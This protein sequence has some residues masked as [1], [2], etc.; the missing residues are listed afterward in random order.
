[1]QFEYPSQRFQDWLSQ[2]WVMW[3]GR[4]IN[5][6]EYPWLMGPFGN[7]DVIGDHYIE[8]LA[9]KENL[10]VERPEQNAGLLSSFEEV[11]AAGALN[12]PI[13]PE[14]VSFYTD[15][16]SH[17]MEVWSQWSTMFRPFGWL[18]HRLYSRRLQ[19]LNMPLQPLDTSRGM[20]SEII[21]LVDPATS[22]IKYTIWLRILKSTGQVIYSG[23]YGTSTTPSGDACVKVIFPLPRGN[24]TVLL[25]AQTDESG[26]LSL[27]SS[28]ERFGCPGFYFLLVDSKG[29]HWA[30]Y[31]RSFR[32]RIDVYGD[33]E[34]TLRADHTLT[35]WKRRV[36]ALHYRIDRKSEK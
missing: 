6:D 4:Q 26:N 18:L 8:Q 22:A 28:G 19:Q 25:R 1:M 3:R 11:E 34:G 29:R 13:R 36:L 27:I 17:H 20:R 31:V 30:Q 32:E 9:A 15:T 16:T 7:V 24:A 23:V 21:R 14:V 5:P 35:L 33:D 12:T 10:T 2:R